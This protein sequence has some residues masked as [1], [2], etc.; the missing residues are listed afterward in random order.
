MGELEARVLA[1]TEGQNPVNP[2]F[3]PDGR[4][5]AF[6]S[7]T[8]QTIKKLAITGGTPITLCKTGTP[9]GVSWS[10]EGIVFARDK[11][12]FKVSENGGNPEVIVTVKDGE[13]ITRPQL[14]PGGE[15]VLFTLAM[16]TDPLSVY[17]DG[18]QIVTQT[19]KS[20]ARKILHQGGRDAR[21]LAT[22]HLVYALGGTLFAVPFDLK[23]LEAGPGAVP[24]VE[25]V[26]GTSSGAAQFSFAD[27]GSLIYVPGLALGAGASG[28]SLAFIDRKGNVAEMKLPPGSYVYPRV[29]RDGKR[30]AYE[31][32]E[33]GGKESAIWIYELS[34]A[35][36]PNR[37]TLAGTGANRYP[38][39]S[40]DGTRVAFQ[41][42]REGDQ[43][44]WWQ[45]ADGSGAAERLT[46]PGHGVAHK[47]DS[48]SPDGQTF[49]FTAAKGDAEALWTFSMRDKK[50]TLFREDPAASLGRSVFS[51]NGRWLAYQQR[52]GA[53]DLG[54]YVQ[55]YPPTPTRFQISKTRGFNRFP[56]WSPDGK[57]LFYISGTGPNIVEVSVTEQPSFSFT[58]L[59]LLPRPFQPN[60]S[61]FVRGYDLHPDGKRFIGVVTA[62]EGPNAASGQPSAPQIQVVLNWFEDVKQRVAQ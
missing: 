50:A 32:D 22:G 36:E 21:Y 12:I 4:Y 24:L 9:T 41:S 51:P 52:V 53:D 18:G 35:H 61:T 40:S 1:G 19:L 8:D 34:G 48:W 57:E 62:G 37:L 49:S 10:K 7:P 23:R 20:G 47:P 14:L 46:K 60:G 43:G 54:I 25:G 17:W 42:D 27:N 31:S 28:N 59:P 55:T 30:V 13:L 45:R 16:G 58:V 11:N 33:G 39:W 5:V 3:S 29:S 6:H 26:R 2:V 38:I 15:A 56:V 44:I